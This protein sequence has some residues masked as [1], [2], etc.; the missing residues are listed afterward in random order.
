MVVIKPKGGFGGLGGTIIKPVAL[1]NVRAFGRSSKGACRLSGPAASSMV[2]MRSNM[3]SAARRLLQIG[4]VLVE[5]GSTCLA[6]WK[7]NWR[8]SSARRVYE[9]GGLPRKT[10]GIIGLFGPERLGKKTKLQ[11]PS[12]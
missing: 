10:K 6:D 12:E 9:V 8:P 11:S 1:A 2:W 7:R 5:E 4:T 3:C